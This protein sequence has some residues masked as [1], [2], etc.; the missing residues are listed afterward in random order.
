MGQDS[1]Q[2]V[3]EFFGEVAGAADS[4]R[5]LSR[6]DQ[7]IQFHILNEQPFFIRV[8]G[9]KVSSQSGETGDRD[10][11]KVL[12]IETDAATITALLERRRTL[13]EALFEG[14]VNIYGNAAKEHVIAWLS[15]LFRTG[16]I[17]N[18]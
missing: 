3:A 8:S 16:G 9:G 15:K 4:Q 13:G 12:K 18:S 14:K 10:F 7:I 5:E 6:Y 17:K 2:R 1:F 11:Q